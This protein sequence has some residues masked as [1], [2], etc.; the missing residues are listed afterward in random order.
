MGFLLF[1]LFV[2]LVAL[3]YRQYGYL[4]IVAWAICIIWLYF[5]RKYN[6]YKDTI[7]LYTNNTFEKISI[8][9]P[10]EF[11]HLCGQIVSKLWYTNVEV[12]KWGKDWGVDIWCYKWK[13]KRGIQCK[14]YNGNH[15]VGV[16]QLRALYG[17]VH[18]MWAK[19]IM[20]TT[21]KCSKEAI[22]YCQE[23][24]I[25]IRNHQTFKDEFIYLIE[26]I[27]SFKAWLV[28]NFV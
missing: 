1:V 12:T 8:M 23:N 9:D 14:R 18:P 6:R 26:G 5:I 20:M 28:I 13:Q 25:I 19:G 3:L 4:V 10:L 27:P 7:K 24:G 2:L 22:L 11:E 16:E 17:S 21:G 15:L